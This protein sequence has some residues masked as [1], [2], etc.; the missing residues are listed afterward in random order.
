MTGGSNIDS[1][2]NSK[3]RYDTSQTLLT[4]NYSYNMFTDL[5]YKGEN[6]FSNN[7]NIDELFRIEYQYKLKLTFYP[8]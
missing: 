1:Y 2:K 7:F 6:K 5:L 4:F 3:Y 8:N